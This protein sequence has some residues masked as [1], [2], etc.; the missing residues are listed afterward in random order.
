MRYGSLKWPCQNLY[1][2]NVLTFV[3]AI[4][5][6]R[7][8]SSGFRDPP[9]LQKIHRDDEFI[10]FCGSGRVCVF[11]GVARVRMCSG[12]SYRRSVCKSWKSCVLGHRTTRHL[13]SWRHR[14]ATGTHAFKHSKK[15]RLPG[16]PGHG[17][18]CFNALIFCVSPKLYLKTLF[19]LPKDAFLW[20]TRVI[21]SGSRS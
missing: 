10:A 16:T 1:S 18:C 9:L 21:H 12:V 8:I 20:I 17:L 5:I 13:T 15:W 4:K 2:K 7:K 11:G 3:T 19:K 14:S 6:Q